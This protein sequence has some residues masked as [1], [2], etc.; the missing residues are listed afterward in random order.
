M[1]PVSSPTR[2]TDNAE[3]EIRLA[4]ESSDTATIH[5]LFEALHTHNARLDPW[6]SLANDWR[7]VLDEYLRHVRELRHGITLL[8]WRD[9]VPV[10]LLMMNEWQDSPLFL[11]RFWVE[12]LALYTIPSE[13]GTGVAA[14][15]LERGRAWARDRGHERVQLYVTRSNDPA[16]QF[17]QRHGF[18]PVQ[19]IWR[20]E[21]PA[22]EASPT[23]NRTNGDSLL[24]I[25]NQRFVNHGSNEGG[26]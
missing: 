25:A 21:D 17:Y 11:H 26:E 15:L 6:F 1:S 22:G 16:R 5:T 8:A 13:R 14:L 10:G 19:E 18:Q 23:S 20:L 4:R 7:N 9:D 2:I 3:V 24:P 12:I